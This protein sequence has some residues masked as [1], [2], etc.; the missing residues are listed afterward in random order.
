MVSLLDRLLLRRGAL[1]VAG[2][3]LLTLG[4][5]LGLELVFR[6]NV[7]LKGDLEPGESRWALIAALALWRVPDLLAPLLPL[8]AVLAVPIT[9]G[10]LLR[11][12]QVALLCAAGLSPRR[13]ARPLLLLAVLVGALDWVVRDLV[14]PASVL[15]QERVEDRLS[16]RP[17]YGREWRDP[18]TGAVW[19]AQRVRLDAAVPELTDV[20]VV[21]DGQ[22]LAHAVRLRWRE[23]AWVLQGAVRWRRGHGEVPER[24]E[25]VAE[26]SEPAL[27]PSVSPPELAR[28]L[29][30]RRAQSSAALLAEAS[31]A[32]RAVVYRRWLAVLGTPLAALLAAAAFIRLAHA[33]SLLTASV[34]AVLAGAAP[35]VL[36]ALGGLSLEAS[37]LPPEVAAG[38]VAG[39][40]GLG[41]LA[42]WWRALR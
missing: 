40:V 7:L 41:S 39:I 9:V 32:D 28:L 33:E 34:R 30:S 35:P 15:G 37:R 18:G 22:E 36:L 38:L 3:L 5:V 11:R 14:Q 26:L 10:P 25:R 4:L 12:R 13:L 27:L 20:L 21:P 19:H 42:V 23:G 17:R 29:I 8:A 16:Q 6:L 24:L 1:A 31:P 2:V